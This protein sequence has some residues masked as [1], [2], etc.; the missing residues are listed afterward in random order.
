MEKKR[1]R[2]SF[3]LL[4]FKPVISGEDIVMRKPMAASKTPPVRGSFATAAHYAQLSAQLSAP[5]KIPRV[6]SIVPRVV[7]PVDGT[8][9]LSGGP[10]P[11]AAAVGEDTRPTKIL[12]IPKTVPIHYLDGVTASEFK[13]ISLDEDDVSSAG[14]VLSYGDNTPTTTTAPAT[15]HHKAARMAAVLYERKIPPDQYCRAEDLAAMAVFV[16]DSRRDCLIWKKALAHF[17]EATK[18]LEATMILATADA[19]ELEQLQ[20]EVE[21]TKRASDEASVPC[22][23]TVIVKFN[24]DM[25]RWRFGNIA[26]KEWLNDEI[27]CFYLEL[28]K[29]RDKELCLRDP[30]RRPS[31]FLTTT[32]YTKLMEGNR[33]SYDL[34]KRWTRDV[35]VFALDKLF[36]PCHIM[37]CHWIL[38]VVFVSEGV[39]RVYDSLPYERTYVAQ[40]IVK[41]LNC[42]HADKKHKNKLP[43]WRTVSSDKTTVPQQTN[44]DDCGMFTLMFADYIWDN[45]PLSRADAL[46][47][48][49]DVTPLEQAN[50]PMF[51]VKVA[52]SIMKGRL[53]YSLYH[54]KQL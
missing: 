44:S 19:K 45:L 27:I 22:C 30:A 29:Q 31:S 7:S 10:G 20:E 28:L 12:K 33:F 37:T 49:L 25:A 17:E 52:D 34:V 54:N 39:V 9:M 23:E 53:P 15:S 50:I 24:V 46:K 16:K 47:A 51:R 35:N 42:E 18:N 40:N 5:P 11:S 6:P 38:C 4:V 13:S 21:R 36:I 48:G 1:P 26:P 3:K 8:S 14:T 32:F 43:K 41:W 2:D